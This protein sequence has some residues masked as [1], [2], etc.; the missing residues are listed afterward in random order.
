MKMKKKTLEHLKEDIAGYKAQIR[1][2]KKEIRE[3]RELSSALKGKKDGKEKSI[4]AKGPSS[5]RGK[6]ST[7]N[8]R[9]ATKKARK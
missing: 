1:A 7:R 6:S 5:K 8:G 3:D 4:K 2:L 9:K